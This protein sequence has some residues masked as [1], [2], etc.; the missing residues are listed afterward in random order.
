MSHALY[1]EDP[2]DEKITDRKI[3]GTIR[4]LRKNPCKG[5]IIIFENDKVTIGYSILIPYWSNEYGGNILHIDELYVKPK[6][7]KH[8][9]AT[10]FLECIARSFND[11]F[12]GLQLEVTPANT[13]AM[14]YYQKLGFRKT[15]NVHLTRKERRQNGR[16]D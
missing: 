11:E 12:V 16:R 7:R 2:P 14:T 4:E 3:S 8:G 9:V 15:G 5:K 6:H 13:R 1:R 10:N